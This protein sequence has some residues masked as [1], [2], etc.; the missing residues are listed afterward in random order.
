[1]PNFTDA[2]SPCVEITPVL[3]PLI[4]TEYAA[5]TTEELPVL[6]RYVPAAA[7]GER[8]AAKT[9]DLILYSREQ[10]MK[11][12]ESMG[13]ETPHDQPW[14]IVSIKVLSC[15]CMLYHFIQV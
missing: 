2:V 14:G 9:L 8:P 10:I 13:Q 11:E 12:N 3:E 7:L 5:R 6:S 15:F 4:R 1:M